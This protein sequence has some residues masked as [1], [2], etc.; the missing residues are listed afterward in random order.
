MRRN[1]PGCGGGSPTCRANYS[2]CHAGGDIAWNLPD[3]LDDFLAVLEQIEWILSED[4]TN[5]SYD[6]I[7][8]GSSRG[9][10]SAT[11]DDSDNEITKY[12]EF[13]GGGDT[14]VIYLESEY[15][16]TEITITYENDQKVVFD[17]T[18]TDSWTVKIAE[19]N[20]KNVPDYQAVLLLVR[21]LLGK[22]GIRFRGDSGC[23]GLPWLNL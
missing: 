8:F 13:E 15:K 10:G 9:I 21:T 2:D 4:K 12:D 1:R 17:R 16:P 19:K 3:S 14:E 18:G 20:P 5:I 23:G 22:Q 6:E 7:N 11:F